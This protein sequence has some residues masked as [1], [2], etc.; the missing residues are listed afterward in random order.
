MKSKKNYQDLFCDFYFA[1]FKSNESET[2]AKC[3]SREDIATISIFARHGYR[4]EAKK[5]AKYHDQLIAAASF[6]IDNVDSVLLMWLGVTS[7]SLSDLELKNTFSSYT[8]PLQTHYNL[9][10]LLLIMCQNLQSIRRKKWCPIVC[11]VHSIEKDGPLR[12]YIKNYASNFSTCLGTIFKS[13]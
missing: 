3:F 11:Q 5:Y 6:V 13:F 2:L 4:T 7:E 8:K 1:K 10:R 12:F 9:G